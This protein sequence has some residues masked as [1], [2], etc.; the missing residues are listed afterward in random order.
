MIENIGD[1]YKNYGLKFIKTAKKIISLKLWT[2]K[3]Q[4]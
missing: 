3:C 2:F 4:F 1:K